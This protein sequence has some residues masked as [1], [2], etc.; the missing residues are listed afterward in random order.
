MNHSSASMFLLDTPNLVESQ[1]RMIYVIKKATIYLGK[2]ERANSL[3]VTQKCALHL[4]IEA[5]GHM[6]TKFA[7]TVQVEERNARRKRDQAQQ[8]HQGGGGHHDYHWPRH[9]LA[10][11]LGRHY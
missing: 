2:I 6:V 1:I 5:S 3:M 9:N 4:T 10:M 8:N 11:I 7:M